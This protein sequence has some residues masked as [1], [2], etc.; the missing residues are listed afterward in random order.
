MR[1]FVRQQ[2]FDLRGGQPPQRGGGRQHYRT[3]PP[4]FNRRLH[5]GKDQHSERARDAKP[6]AH[7]IRN[8]PDLPGPRHDTPL[9]AKVRP[10]TATALHAWV[11]KGETAPFNTTILHRGPF[12]NSSISVLITLTP[13]AGAGSGGGAA[14][15]WRCVAMAKGRLGISRAISD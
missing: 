12:T 15:S 6:A 13:L 14:S 3:K 11:E 9:P 4:D 2:P 8:L 1:Q 5:H 7:P 10:R